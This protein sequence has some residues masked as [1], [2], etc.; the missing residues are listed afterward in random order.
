MTFG[1]SEGRRSRRILWKPARS[2]AMGF[3]GRHPAIPVIPS[4]VG[5]RHGCRGCWPLFF[6]MPG[7]RFSLASYLLH[8]G[9]R[10]GGDHCRNRRPHHA[11]QSKRMNSKPKTRVPR[12]TLPPIGT[13]SSRLRDGS[14]MPN[15]RETTAA[16]RVLA[17]PSTHRFLAFPETDAFRAHAARW[18]VIPASISEDLIRRSAP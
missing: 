13:S 14:P 12:W 17:G 2:E 10:R 16:I 7:A 11:R 3:H 4:T 1:S 6:Q 5:P 15:P 18:T 8:D 9:T